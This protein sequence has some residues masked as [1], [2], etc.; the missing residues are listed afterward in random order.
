[1][2][3]RFES[4]PAVGTNAT[5]TLRERQNHVTRV[6]K[7]SK[8]PAVGEVDRMTK[9]RVPGH[10]RINRGSILPLSGHGWSAWQTC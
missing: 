6:G 8:H 4:L 3:F 9:A 1:V 5:G 2:G 10:R 7:S